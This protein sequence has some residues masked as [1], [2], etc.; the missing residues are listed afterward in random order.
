MKIKSIVLSVIVA[1]VLPSCSDVVNYNDDVNDIFA[2]DGAPVIN[3]IYAVDD[4]ESA[5]P[6]EKGSLNQMIR[7]EGKNLSHV[8]ELTFNGIH[9][10]CLRYTLHLKK[11]T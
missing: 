2:S 5:L 8:K 3:A 7:I 9:T 6:L 10:I 1:S 11:A 4:T